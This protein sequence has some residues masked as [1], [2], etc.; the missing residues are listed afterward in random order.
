M[1]VSLSVASWEASLPVAWRLSLPREWAGDG[2]RRRK[3]GVPVEVEFRTQPETALERIGR[4]LEDGVPAGVVLADA[5]YGAD[6]RFLESMGANAIK[7][8]LA[9]CAKWR[10]THWRNAEF[11]RLIPQRLRISLD[12]RFSCGCEKGLFSF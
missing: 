9:T 8:I 4:A 3:A 7:R 1:S 2:A 11:R 5:G 6:T 10:I 12:S